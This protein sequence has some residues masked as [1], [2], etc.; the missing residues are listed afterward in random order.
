MCE[1]SWNGSEDRNVKQADGF[2]GGI[3]GMTEVVDVPI[4]AK[5]ADDDGT[6]L[7]GDGVPLVANGDFA[8]VADANADLLAPDVGPPRTFRGWADHR[9]LGGERLPVGG[10]GCLAEFAVEFVLVGVWDELVE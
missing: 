6:G 9:A 5:A 10:V 4:W 7:G 2:G 1:Q 8:I 3:G